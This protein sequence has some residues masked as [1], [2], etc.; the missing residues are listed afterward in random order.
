MTR[1][2]QYRELMDIIH[3]GSYHEEET[4]QDI[5][6]AGYRKI[7]CGKWAHLGCDEWC[8]SQC[9]HVITTEGS[10]EKPTTKFCENCGASMEVV[11]DEYV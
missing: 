2:E 9:G 4:A 10:W 7:P 8:C 5:L 6:D 3:D 1:E 11:D